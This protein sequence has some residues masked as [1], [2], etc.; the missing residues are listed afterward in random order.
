MLEYSQDKIEETFF[1]TAK[2]MDSIEVPKTA[3]N[4]ERKQYL[5]TSILKAV[6]RHTPDDTEKIVGITSVD[7]FVPVLT[8]IFGQ[9]QLDGKAAV[10]SIHRLDQKFYG[11]PED[12]DL[13]GLRL[14]KEI[15]HELGH[16]YGLVHCVDGNCV[17]HF[18]N[19]IMQVDIKEDKFCETCTREITEKL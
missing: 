8:F 3:L 2:I 4:A 12:V 7:L 19:S 5:S 10:V 17:M 14:G 15:V 6:I 11:L 18:S 16:T 13:L 9:A 1:C